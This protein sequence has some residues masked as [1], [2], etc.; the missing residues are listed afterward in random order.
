MFNTYYGSFRTRTF[1]Q[2]FPNIGE[3]KATATAAQ[4]PLKISD[5]SLTTLFYLL[6]AKYG[7][8]NIAY[9]D[10]NQFKYSVFSKIFMYGPTW[11]RRLEVQ[12]T[13]RTLDE[14]ELV[15]GGQALYNHAFNPSTQPSTNTESALPYI[16]DQNRTIYTKSK[17]E[18]YSI[19]IDLL[20]TD[21]TGEFIGK[22]KDLFLTVVASP[23]PLLYTTY[24]ENT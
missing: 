2:I 21:V 19:L 23:E 9:S 12:D 15:R 13:I 11:E 4:I 22:F 24:E 3:F 7:N 16:N 8:S 20:E 10:E 14:D 1:A 17:L 18:G 6:Y 5:N